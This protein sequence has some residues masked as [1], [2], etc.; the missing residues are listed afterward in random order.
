MNTS[1]TQDS[2]SNERSQ[3]PIARILIT[4][5]TLAERRSGK[6]AATP[7]SQGRQPGSLTALPVTID[8]AA[9]AQLYNSQPASHVLREDLLEAART[10]LMKYELAEADMEIAADSLARAMHLLLEQHGIRK[11]EPHHMAE[12]ERDVLKWCGLCRPQTISTATPAN[13]FEKQHGQTS[14]KDIIM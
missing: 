7:A 12:L 14:E 2:R 13:G 8:V 4:P 1:T 6:Q 11:L 10:A 3:P 5:S 9:L